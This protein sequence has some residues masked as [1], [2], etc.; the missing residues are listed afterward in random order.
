M[1]V[2]RGINTAVFSSSLTPIFSGMA[3]NPNPAEPAGAVGAVGV[4]VPPCAEPLPLALAAPVVAGLGAGGAGP[5]AGP[6]NAGRFVLRDV[7]GT[8]R[9]AFVDGT[10]AHLQLRTYTKRRAAVEPTAVRPRETWNADLREAGVV[11]SI[12]VEGLPDDAEVTVHIDGTLVGTTCM[13][14][15]GLK[16]YKDPGHRTMQMVQ[17]Y[18]ASHAPYIHDNFMPTTGMRIVLTA[19]RASARTEPYIFTDAC[20]LSVTVC[21]AGIFRGPATTTW[22]AVDGSE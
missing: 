10:H 5:G 7:L 21:K 14:V 18:F 6:E 11:S 13:H 8:Q 20:N 1:C 17:A 22:V 16:G 9:V 19:I 4:I 2:L 3:A 15:I 12:R